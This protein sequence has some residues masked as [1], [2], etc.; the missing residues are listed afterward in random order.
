MAHLEVYAVFFVA[1]E[2]AGVSG[3]HYAAV[4]AGLPILE[5]FLSAA[6]AEVGD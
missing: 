6:E 4:E 1:V 5:E 3:V 2:Q